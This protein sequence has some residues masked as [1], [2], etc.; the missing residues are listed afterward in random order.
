MVF[1]LGPVVGEAIVNHPD[2]P[3]ISFTGSTATGK[4][5]AQTAAPMLKKLSLEV[6]K[7][8]WYM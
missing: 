6:N 1:G 2:V 5:I 7:K 8:V 3:I 4:A